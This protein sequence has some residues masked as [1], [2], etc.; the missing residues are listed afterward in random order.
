M[1]G[2]AFLLPPPAGSSWAERN[3]PP[4]Q[5][6]L[7][8]R[9]GKRRG[10]RTEAWE[11]CA[12][13][14]D[15]VPDRFFPARHT[16][17]RQLDFYGALVTMSW[18][19]ATAVFI[20]GLALLVGPWK[21]L[22]AT[23]FLVPWL[24]GRATVWELRGAGVRL[25][26]EG[27]EVAWLRSGRFRYAFPLRLVREVSLEEVPG[28]RGGRSARC[29][30]HPDSGV[31]ELTR[32]GGP[33]VRVRLS[34]P[35]KVAF[36]GE[37]LRFLRM[38]R[39]PR[40]V[41]VL[42]VVLTVDDPRGLTA[43]LKG[44]VRES[45][46]PVEPGLPAQPAAPPPVVPAAAAPP[47]FARPTPPLAAGPP[48]FS[49]GPGLVARDLHLSYGQVRA[50]AGVSLEVKPGEVVGLVGL[51]GAGKTTTLRMLTG[52]LRPDRGWVTLS[53]HDLWDGETEGMAARREIGAVPDAFP[54]YPRL[55][56]REYLDFVSRLY[57][58]P[59]ALARRRA[60]ELADFLALPSETL[61]RPAGT[62]STGTRRK[63]LIVAG[64]VHDPPFLVMDEP[65][66][67]LDP[68]AQQG[69]RAWLG[70]RR[71]AGRG[72]LLSSHTLGLVADACTRLVVMHRGAVA[73]AG[74]LPELAATFGLPPGDAEGVF[75]A[76]IGTAGGT[77]A[78]G[79]P[80]SP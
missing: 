9:P 29:Q 75:F 47:A 23:V 40:P 79:R 28:E 61:D 20:V 5:Q 22:A 57:S 49:V 53:G 65:T 25:T 38:A 46:T 1:E 77:P 2:G 69:F 48:P 27:L 4:S 41:T 71:A 70:A 18:V 19:E 74:R 50:V 39:P 8:G 80:G 52:V 7:P 6:E 43:A 31:L 37:G 17:S 34:A 33:A 66:S 68:E 67:G 21:A 78:G 60:D 35:H 55:T 13:T 72:V 24:V 36:G 76:A 15:S 11:V 42:E 10:S 3:G 51:N 16:A 58:V 45:A 26:P 63:L 44:L 12:L 59:L 64:A 32:G 73:A 30:W 56:G 54:V 62:Y 14:A